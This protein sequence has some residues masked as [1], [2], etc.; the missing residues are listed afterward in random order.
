[1]IG[2][3][4]VALGIDRRMIIS[5]FKA[6]DFE[7]LDLSDAAMAHRLTCGLGSSVKET[8]T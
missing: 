1:L 3:V 5:G 6:C 7:N 2:I 8:A 4:D